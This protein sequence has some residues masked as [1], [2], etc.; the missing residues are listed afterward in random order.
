[1]TQ[2]EPVRPPLRL[3][4]I[5]QS[6]E[7]LAL[8]AEGELFRTE[9][10]E[11]SLQ[12]SA[13]LRKGGQADA[14]LCEMNLPGV[15]GL[16][17]HQMLVKEEG[18]IPRHFLLLHPKADKDFRLKALKAGIHDLYTSLPDPK[19]LAKRLDYLRKYP[20][21]SGEA[22]RQAATYRMPIVKRAF[23]ILASGAGLLVLS[24]FF[25][26]IAAMIRLESKGSV[27]YASKRVGTGYRVFDFYKFRSMYTGADLQ[28]KSLAHQNQYAASQEEEHDSLESSCPDCEKL[29]AYCSPPLHID[30]EVVCERRYLREKKA[31]AGAAFVKILND[32]R[33]T[34]VGRFIRKTSID[35]LPQLFNVLK[36]DMSIVGNRPLPLYEAEQLTSDDWGERFLGPAGITGLWQV[37]KRGKKDMSDEERKQLDNY[38]ARHY[39]FWYDMKIILR[40][41]PALLQKEDV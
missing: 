21:V 41:I 32:P 34:R 29:G 39:S 10:V 25:L 20:P 2:E 7:N 8:L 40:T 5:G 36:G 6:E 22:A 35:E 11:N 15:S 9:R 26:L 12:A 19:I 1:M 3:L 38:Y 30:G 23:D 37:N 24:P 27:F 33:V 18:G 17:Y 31:K 16:D 13:W 4:Y 14:I 28:L